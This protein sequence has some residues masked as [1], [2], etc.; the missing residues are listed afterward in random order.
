[1]IAQDWDGKRLPFIQ[2]RVELL[3][4]HF[5]F[6]LPAVKEHLNDAEEEEAE[7]IFVMK[8]DYNRPSVL[9][10]M[11]TLK[12]EKLKK[13]YTLRVNQK[14]FKLLGEFSESEIQKRIQLNKLGKSFGI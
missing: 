2:S 12:D 1:M 4:S 3:P 9:L 10:K 5:F 8:S 11:Y 7:V 13:V 14:D 6:S